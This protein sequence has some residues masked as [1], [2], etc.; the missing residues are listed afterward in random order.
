MSSFSTVKT[1]FALL[2]V[3]FSSVAINAASPAA[4][5]YAGQYDVLTIPEHSANAYRQ[6]ELIVKFRTDNVASP[7]RLKGAK[8]K[9]KANAS[10][11]AL[12]TLLS[13]YGLEDAEELMPLTGSMV[14]PA[15]HRAKSLNGK[16]MTDCDL[17]SLYVLRFDPKKVADLRAVAEEFSALDDVDYAEPN[18][19]VYACSTGTAA[20]YTADPMYAQQWGISAI[21]LDKLWNEPVIN[22]KRPVIAILDTGV[23]IDH[24]D[25]ADN[26]WTNELEAT[27]AD[28]TDD[29]GNGFADDIHGWDFVNQSARMR[30]NNGHGTHCAGIAAA[31]GGNG[32]GI[33][34]A[35]PDALIMPITVMQSDGTG[36]VGTIIKGI[37][38]AVA[39]GADVLSMS[40]G[41]TSNSL[42]EYDALAKAYQKAVLVAAAGNN[43]KDIY[44]DP[45]FPAAYA[46]VLGVMASDSSG[47]RADFSNY[48]PDGPLMTT[49]NGEQLY[50]YELMAPGVNIISAYPGGGYKTFN[51]TSMACPLVAGAISRLYQCKEISSYELIF[52]DLIFTLKDGLFGILDIEEAYKSNST[53]LKPTLIMVG[54]RLEDCLGDADLR[55]DAGEI[56]DLYPT[57]RNFG[58]QAKNIKFKLSLG[59]NED[60][61]IVEFISSEV[62][63]GSQLGTFAHNESKN[64]LRFKIN[65]KCV[66]G[67]HIKFVLI[68]TCDNIEED[69]EQEIVLKVENGIELGGII[70]EDM[71][72]YPDKHY[73]VTSLLGIPDGVTLTIMPGTIL[74]FH[75]N[76][77]ISVA[78]GGKIYAVGKPEN[79][80]VFTKGELDFG[81]I[82]FLDFGYHSTISFCTVEKFI[83][84]FRLYYGEPYPV[85]KSIFINNGGELNNFYSF[86]NSLITGNEILSSFI[87]HNS[88]NIRNRL[89]YPNISNHASSIICNGNQFGQYY[90]Y[91]ADRKYFSMGININNP[92]FINIVD[93]TYLGSNNEAILRN[94]VYDI[95]NPLNGNINLN[96]FAQL[97]IST[98]L[99]RPNY[100]APGCV[101]KVVVD[102]YDAQDEFD[103]L[104]DLGVGRHKFEV[105]F[106]K[107]M[108]RK[109]TPMVAMGVRPPY[110]QIAIAEDGFWRTE[111]FPRQQ[112][113]TVLEWKSS[114]P[115][116]VTV[117]EDGNITANKP[118]KAVIT[119]SDGGVDDSCEITVD[120]APKFQL[121][122]DKVIIRPGEDVTLSVFMLP[123]GIGEKDPI[124]WTTTNEAVATVDTHGVVTGVAEGEV[125]I[126]AKV[127]DYMAVCKVI[128]AEDNFTRLM[129]QCHNKT[130]APDETTKVGVKRSDDD[131]ID[132][133][134]AYLTIKGRDTYDGLNRIYVGGAEDL[135][136]F[137]CPIED[138]RF[139]VNVQSAG[140]MSS[141]FMAEAG[142]GK[143]TLTWENPEENFDD[144]LGYN[145]Y[146]YT[147]NDNYEAGDTIRINE[148]LLDSEE[149]VDYDI[150]P[151]K[152]YN[153]YYKVLRTSLEENS[154][155]KV[156][157]ATPRAAGKGDANASGNVDVADVVTEVNYMVG[158]EPKPFIFEAA[159][160]NDDSDIDILDVVGTV[161]IIM[162]PA[163]ANDMA[164]A[165]SVATY[166]VEDGIL[167]VDCPVELAGVQAEL[168]GTRGSTEIAVLPALK[169]MENT[170]DWV[171]DEAYR[172]VAFSLSGKTLENGR[173]ALLSIG[174]ADLSDLILVDPNGNRVMAIEGS[175]S[176]I[177]SVV[178]QQMK[179]PTPNPFVDVINVPVIIGT[180]GNHDVELSIHDLSG[181]K[182]FSHRA[183]LG[184]GEHKVTLNAGALRSGFYMLTLTVD[185]A[186]VQT[187]KVIKK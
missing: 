21:N 7:V 5:P 91:A 115:D 52:T 117:D 30:D 103:Q 153:Y 15:P 26:I 175:H 167:Y 54:Y 112:E 6:G 144:M 45:M 40:F 57:V 157:S 121:D 129:L 149:F 70:T 114:D 77:G 178:M 164:S 162:A 187:H 93:G 69:F 83:Y 58:G 63:F 88:T 123:E 41:G 146:R 11:T 145:L 99:T 92:E 184:H 131:L 75:D 155:S 104:P 13:K 132:I 142:V 85:S 158:R 172:F 32:I 100:A 67:R 134:T 102:G 14:T 166:T 65:D 22:T 16:E 152:T 9:V 137:P 43:G 174:D 42:A 168:S 170:G 33:T 68:G 161:N 19:I 182:V 128:V 80:I 37:D 60:P 72:L 148:K 171:S 150:V 151:G 53:D 73:I 66:D 147:L 138:F 35:N 110:T 34:G 96:T 56:I 163:A 81:V 36:D 98:R 62:E 64:P 126:A 8:G 179:A 143:V 24:P 10:A 47:S 12:N 25:L 135:E 159:D 185:G 177:S 90:D 109:A 87:C 120:P 94:W 136:Y 31:V 183:Q 125:E 48:D 50:N 95:K 38:Y 46:F 101:W 59:E 119:V 84:D 49:F 140:A 180:D 1:A 108:N 28:N 124:D 61:E 18:Y 130:V 160:V 82:N 29:D 20:D 154:P 89:V 71:T 2:A 165:M 156:V 118:G 17:S 4:D 44:C 113:A 111:R 51:G 23:D 76:T 97:D 79:R 176:G 106:S 55:A 27:G 116:I 3:A 39:N 181:T 105:Y 141:G 107:Q 127:G 139:N 186:A 173:H 133:Y 86:E 169:G 74:K 78:N 122:K